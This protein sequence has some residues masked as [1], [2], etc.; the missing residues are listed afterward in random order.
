[1]ATPDPLADAADELYGLTP[2][3]FTAARNARA[4]AA[5][6]EGERDLAQAI[7]G[8][9]KPTA[10]AWLANQL[11]RQDPSALG[12]LLDLGE[13]L[14][15][16][17]AQLDG[18]EMRRLSREQPKVVGQLV[19]R[20]TAIAQE[21]GK[22]VSATT[23]HDLET[24][25]RAAVADADAAD[26]L[27]AGRLAIALEHN[28]FGLVAPGNLSL[29]RAP[30][31]A[32]KRSAET[33]TRRAGAAPTAPAKPTRDERKAQELADA[34][35]ELEDAQAAVEVTEA[36]QEQAQAAVDTAQEAV[37]DARET[38]DGLREQMEQ[39]KFAVSRVEGE[40]REAKQRLERAARAARAAANALADA[41]AKRD[42][43]KG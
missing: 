27:M 9:A 38:L 43:I 14:R 25:L 23:A 12:P 30:E 29:V 15:A 18:G 5:Q 35:Q 6:S 22:P 16:A 20:A 39:A 4:K 41:T 11:V 7:R 34:E 17:T 21:A 24:T 40:L 1:M 13:A 36:G 26:Q 2:E 8:L 33:T 3:E 42:R 28:G 32:S 19:R 10:A 37:E 31:A